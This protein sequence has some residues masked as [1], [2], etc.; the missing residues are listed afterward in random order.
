MANRH[1]TKQRGKTPLLIECKIKAEAARTTSPTWEENLLQDL[2][3]QHALILKAAAGDP[4]A[5]R[6]RDLLSYMIEQKIAQ[7]SER[8]NA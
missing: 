8:S 6:E 3:H 5:R 4:K 1:S 7:R 2:K